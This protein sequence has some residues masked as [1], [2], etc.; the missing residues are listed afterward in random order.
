MSIRAPL[1]IVCTIVCISALW[2]VFFPQA[3]LGDSC[4]TGEYR[5]WDGYP[6]GRLGQCEVLG[7]TE[8]RLHITPEIEGEINPSPWYSFQIRPYPDMDVPD[9]PFKVTL[10]YGEHEHRYWPKVSVDRWR[11]SRLDED[12]VEFAG[13]DAVLTLDKPTLTSGVHV[14]AQEV[15]DARR[16]Q[17]WMRGLTERHE[18]VRRLIIGY[19]HGRRPIEALRINE[20]AKLLVLIIGRQ[21]PP[22]VTGAK[23]LFTFVDTL[24]DGEAQA[25]ERPESPACRFYAHYALMV[26]PLL[27]PDGVDLGHW[28]LNAAGVDLNR[29]W[30]DFSQPE[31]NAVGG[32]VQGLAQRGT[33]LALVLDFHSTDRS[34]A[35]TQMARDP[36]EPPG[37][38]K[39]WID[40]A[41]ELG[42]EFDHEPRPLSG[43]GTAKNEFFRAFGV[44][45]I[46]YEVAD[47]A[48]QARIEA[49]AR[50]V[51]VA[52]A[53]LLGSLVPAFPQGFKSEACEDFFCHMGLVNKASLVMLME[54]GLIDKADAAQIAEAIRKAIAGQALP[55][56]ERSA[57]YIDFEALLTEQIGAKAANV[58]LGRSRQDVHGA[59][60]RM[61]TRAR[62]LEVSDALLAA[63]RLALGFANGHKSTPVPAYTHGVQSQPTSL[64]H[65]TLAYVDAMR[66]DFQRLMAAYDRLNLSPL[67][68][69]AGSGSRYGLNRERVAELLGFDAPVDN[70]YDANFV[71]SSE[72]HLEIAHALSLSAVT[73]GQFAQHVHTLYHDPQPWL[74]LDMQGTSGSTIMPQKRSPRAIDR[75]RSQA[76]QVIA[77]AGAITLMAH[78]TSPGMHDYRQ[79]SPLANLMDEAERMYGRLQDLYRWLGVDAERALEELDRGYS[80]M[81]ELADMLVVEADVPFR[82]A[83]GYAAGLTD[84]A[85]AKG[86]RAREL[87]D[88]DFRSVYR[89]TILEP[90]PL[91]VSRLREALDATQ[92]LARRQGLGSPAASEM[93][94]MLFSHRDDLAAQQETLAVK[95]LHTRQAIDRL[96]SAFAQLVD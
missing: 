92:M 81:T 14:S 80:M 28:R 53:E 1:S 26:V 12:R 89:D 90:L 93:Q 35:Y 66:R 94:R 2:L 23:A 59:T 61:V 42:A 40:L 21:H 20:S 27:N 46:T 87:T 11:W 30:G 41:H 15:V 71:S 68:A 91:P 16:Y 50:A 86:V 48:S 33:R 22:E 18:H 24:L 39:A 58:H 34:L 64:G 49:N 88:E 75:L 44:P 5:L 7:S 45:S 31:T 10:A 36:T 32:Y 25:C 72:F 38:A 17:N 84:L 13:G 74:Y 78:N 70:T 60:R 63:R 8:V 57:N 95:R 56:A 54:T 62:L 96:E 65:F 43:L 85:R 83:H 47:E 55:G 82:S 76:S 6:G 67:G 19:S 52:T 79:L 37:F 51:A 9:A 3:A 77:D 29:D 4:E 69:A 73:I